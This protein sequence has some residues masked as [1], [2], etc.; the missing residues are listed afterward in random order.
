MRKEIFKLM[1]WTICIVFTFSFSFVFADEEVTSDKY[2][3]EKEE[4]VAK[5]ISGKVLDIMLW[6]GYAT[7]LGVLIF[8]GIK[9]MMSG[10]NEKA[11]LKNLAPMF[12]VG[13]AIIVFC[14]PI[15]L[16]VAYLSGNDGAE[17]IIQVGE[18]AGGMF[19]GTTNNSSGDET[20]T[21]DA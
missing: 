3:T 6:F 5:E 14:Y 16:F 15:G 9:Y 12:L 18:D 19:T 17:E 4:M 8:I 20:S 21:D 1:V 10:A 13:L 2:S 7:A 11:A